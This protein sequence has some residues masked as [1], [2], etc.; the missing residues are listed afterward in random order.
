MTQSTK[1]KLSDSISGRFYSHTG[2][3]R[4]P[5]LC[6]YLLDSAEKLHCVPGFRR[7]DG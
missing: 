6:F 3:G 4:Y 1:P 2:E 5:V 7:Y